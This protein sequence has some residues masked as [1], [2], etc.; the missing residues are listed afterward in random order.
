MM[1]EEFIVTVETI[2]KL[3]KYVMNVGACAKT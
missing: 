2:V 3:I 1:L